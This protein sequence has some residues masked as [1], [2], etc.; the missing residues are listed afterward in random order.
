VPGCAKI[1]LDFPKTKFRE[2]EKKPF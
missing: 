1:R 2:I